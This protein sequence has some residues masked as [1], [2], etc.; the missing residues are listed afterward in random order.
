M[1]SS[2]ATT[3][4]SVFLSCCALGAESADCLSQTWWQMFFVFVFIDVSTSLFSREYCTLY[5]FRKAGKVSLNDSILLPLLCT[6][7][8]CKK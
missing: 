6:K 1:S 5:K 7:T 4:P 8:M 2:K 3:D